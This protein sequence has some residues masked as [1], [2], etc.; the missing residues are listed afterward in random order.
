MGNFVLLLGTNPV[1]EK[2]VCDL[3]SCAAAEIE[4]LSFAKADN[5]VEQ[6]RYHETIR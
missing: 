6:E 2:N 1:N 5:E 4:R 3:A